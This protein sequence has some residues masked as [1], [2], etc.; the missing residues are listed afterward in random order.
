[1]RHS[2]RRPSTIRKA[3]SYEIKAGMIDVN[4][5]VTTFED[6]LRDEIREFGS[7]APLSFADLNGIPISQDYLSTFGRLAKNVYCGRMDFPSAIREISKFAPEPPT[8]EKI[9]VFRNLAN[10]VWNEPVLEMV[11]QIGEKYKIAFVTDI[12]PFQAEL[13]KPRLEKI[14]PLYTSYEM[15]VTKPE[16]YPRAARQMGVEPHQA[17]VMDDTYAR[18]VE[19]KY[20]FFGIPFE[21]ERQVVAICVGEGLV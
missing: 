5:V 15:G 2:T 16:L 3:K 20:G 21:D 19:T 12:A 10:P 4:G 14:A 8:P 1:M 18:V 6:P 9:E 7:A 11:E 13:M 17:F